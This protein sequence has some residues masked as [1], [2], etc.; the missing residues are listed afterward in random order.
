MP[1]LNL[2]PKLLALNP[3][4]LRDALAQ[5]PLKRSEIGRE[6]FKHTVTIHYAGT[7]E[8]GG[9]TDTAALAQIWSE[10]HYHI[11]KVWGYFDP[12]T[13]QRPIFGDG[14]MY[15]LAVLPSG[16]PVLLR[17]LDAILYH[18]AN[19][20][21]N[22]TSVSV[23][24]L[25]GV[26]QPM[27]AQQWSGVEALCDALI[28]DFQMGSR[29]AVK[30]HREW[31]RDDGLGQSICPG[32]IVFEQLL[33]YRNPAPELPLGTYQVICPAGLNVRTGPN[34]SYPRANN[35]TLVYPQG[36]RFEVGAIVPDN[37]GMQRF[38]LWDSTGIGFLAADRGLALFVGAQ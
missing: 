22:R 8:P 35:D 37:H 26:G 28:V 29:E 12:K 16:R 38:W 20:V 34:V 18:C 33:H 13:K 5:L 3:I 2:P 1:R 15:H 4:D 21:G 9:E 27:T 19:Q 25:R 11:N 14:I 6:A 32:S 31:P 10:A 36:R 24:T 30:G 17:E 7:E 23:T